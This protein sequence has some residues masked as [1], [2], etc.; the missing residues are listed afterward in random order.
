MVLLPRLNTYIYTLFSCYIFIFE[1]HQII[2]F[3]ALLESQATKK[4][5]ETN[6]SKTSSHSPS[7]STQTTAGFPGKNLADIVRGSTAN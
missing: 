5:E 7:N 2:S 1:P 4:T 6:S 3:Q